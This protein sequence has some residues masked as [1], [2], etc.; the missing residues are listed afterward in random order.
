MKQPISL[1]IITT[2]YDLPEKAL[3]L[4][5]ANNGIKIR[6]ICRPDAPWQSELA[7]A[8]IK[9]DHH[10][11]RHRLDMAAIRQVKKTVKA[12]KFDIIFAPRNNCLSAALIATRGMAVK[13]IAYRG[14]SGHVKK[15][16]PGVWF[17]YLNPRIDRIVCVSD[18]VRNYLSG[19]KI[20]Q[21]R[22]VTIY[23]GHEA[24]WYQGHSSADPTKWHVPKD[25]F[26]AG[27]VGNMRPVKGVN[28]L[29][30]A[31]A[32][33]KNNPDNIHYL[34]VGE[35]R[36]KKVKKAVERSGQNQRIHFI[37]FQKDAW[38]LMNAF[39]V[40]VMPSVEREG[41]PRA[42]IEAMA[43]KVPP[44]VTNVGGMPEIVTNRVNGLIV[45]PQNPHALAEAIQFMAENP[46][47]RL[48]M[49]IA[50]RNT[51]QEKFSSQQ[52][53]NQTMEMFENVLSE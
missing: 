41:F 14:T 38:S 18:S 33:V 28:D 36:D 20:P 25:A 24:A 19:K 13:I 30:Q 15:W 34:F 42:V 26:I 45:P 1:L 21:K 22:L 29:I 12:E 9:I 32:L 53:I 2:K 8:G 23:K 50:A 4:G 17:T 39:S 37:G 11:F 47:K 49:G 44:I 35:V 48:Q 40:F 16:N 43:Q 3:Y 27:F 52:T 5:L 31:T 6:M 7:A 51:V 46:D 10:Y